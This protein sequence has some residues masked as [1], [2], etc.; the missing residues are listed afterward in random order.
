MIMVNW[1]EEI[2]VIVRTM[3]RVREGVFSKD[4]VTEQDFMVEAVSKVGVQGS[5]K[6]GPDKKGLSS[7]FHM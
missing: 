4:M 3:P 2:L 1:G 6:K 5:L 7:N